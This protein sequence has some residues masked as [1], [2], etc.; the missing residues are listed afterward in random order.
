MKP[1]IQCGDSKMLGDLLDDCLST[2]RQVE[3]TDHLEECEAC[4]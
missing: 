1:K 2:D 4:Q 3:L